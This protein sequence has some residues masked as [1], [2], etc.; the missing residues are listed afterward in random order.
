MLAHWTGLLFDS[1]SAI[2]QCVVYE[3]ST[4]IKGSKVVPFPC[5]NTSSVIF[6]DYSIHLAIVIHFKSPEYLCNNGK[7]D[8]R[9]NY[10]WAC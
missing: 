3:C 5:I 10:T 7:M 6:I 9:M 2:L 1:I 8:Y 4:S